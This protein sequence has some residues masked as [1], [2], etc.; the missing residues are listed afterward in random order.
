MKLF[1]KI[2]SGVY[3]IA[4][5]SANHSG[6]LDNAFKI[7]DAAKECGADC[8]KIQTYTA[9]TL[10]LNCNKEYFKI[11]GGLWDGY[12][13]YDLY[14]EAYT[15]WEWQPQIKRYCEEIGLDFLSTPFD[16]T[17][18]DFLEEMGLEF[19]KIA[20]FEL[21]DLP[22]IAYVASKGK[23]IILSCGMGSVEEIEDA[24]DACKKQ[25]NKQVILLKCCSDYPAHF[26]DMKLATIADMM[27]RFSL[28]IGLSDHS[29]GSMA[30]VVAVS[31]GACVIEKH[32]CLSRDID[33]P[34]S[35]FSMEPQEFK[36]MVEA[37]HTVLTLKGES[38]YELTEQEKKSSVYRRSIFCSRDIQKG[39]RFTEKN[40][41]I[42][43]PSYGAKPKYYQELMQ[44]CADRDYA[45]GEP[46]D[47]Q[48]KECKV[49]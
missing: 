34:D 10:T 13:F 18:V 39:E 4:E 8:L 43:R 28:P 9:D 46:I 7:A 38:S 32:L 49:H 21:V 31:I 47:Y 41:R 40:I 23:P 12:T 37:I 15:P 35:K 17:A 24:I 1:D 16:V 27:K 33:S 25:G 30:A 3:T 20:S 2:K 29:M 19:Y 26:A 6:N 44:Q 48:C 42:V 5:L 36:Q 22:L 11:K 45:F 14:Q